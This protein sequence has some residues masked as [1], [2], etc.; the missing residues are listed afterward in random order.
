M[1]EARNREENYFFRYT[2]PDILQTDVWVKGNHM[3]RTILRYDQ[4]D[5]Y[6]TYNMVYLNRESL[7]AEGYC[8]TTKAKCF[9][10]HGPFTE[11]YSKWNIKTPK[12]WLLELDD[13]FVWSLDNKISDQLYHIVDYHK[14]GNI[15]RVYVNDYRGWPA[16]VEIYEDEGQ[17]LD[18]LPTGKP[19]KTYIYDDMDIGGVTDD[20]V[21]PG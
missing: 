18:S 5:K 16:R 15:I 11:T 19:D 21:T 7:I 1:S 2:S 10:G 3:K 14:D 12:D 4:V 20:D 6:N 8:E 9:E 17:S 13:D